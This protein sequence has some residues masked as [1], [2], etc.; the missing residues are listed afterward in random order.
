[1]P[2]DDPS[3]IPYDEAHEFRMTEVVMDRPL[4]RGFE[5]MPSTPALPLAALTPVASAELPT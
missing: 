4:M 5:G 3:V 2:I 1:M